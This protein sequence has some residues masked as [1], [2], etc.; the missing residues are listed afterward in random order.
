[1]SPFRAP[2]TASG[3]VRPLVRKPATDVDISQCPCGT[4]ATSRCPRGARREA[5][6]QA[7]RALGKILLDVTPHEGAVEIILLPA[8]PSRLSA[9]SMPNSS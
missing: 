9:I 8:W 5:Q 1:M 4:A 3:A 6:R 2:S 7:M